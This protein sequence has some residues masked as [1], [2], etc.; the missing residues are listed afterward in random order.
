MPFSLNLSLSPS[1]FSSKILV[2]SFNLVFST[3]LGDNDAFLLM[4]MSNTIPFV[5]VFN[6]CLSYI[7]TLKWYASRIVSQKVSRR[8][9][10]SKMHKLLAYFNLTDFLNLET[11]KTYDPLDALSYSDESSVL[12]QSVAKDC[13]LIDAVSYCYLCYQQTV[14]FGGGVSWTSRLKRYASATNLV[15]LTNHPLSSFTISPKCRSLQ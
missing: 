1:L 8:S 13:K 3:K 12:F 6:N 9:D 4:P 7:P 2:N 10:I 11:Q 14:F 5:E 15:S